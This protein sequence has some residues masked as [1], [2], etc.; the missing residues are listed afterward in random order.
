M[1]IQPRV[2]L[3]V[4]G[5]DAAEDLVGQAVAGEDDVVAADAVVG[6]VA[7]LAPEAV[8]RRAALHRIVV[9]PA[10]DAVLARF[11]VDAVVP[12]VAGDAVVAVAAVGAVLPA[13]GGDGVGAFAALD[14]VF[15]RTGVDVRA[16][17]HAGADH[18]VVVPVV[19][20]DVDACDAAGVERHRRGVPRD[21]VRR[22]VLGDGDAVVRGRTLHV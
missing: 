12:A 10:V 8:A 3:R 19:P 22:R 17:Q 15:A 11:A 14:D 7:A 20:V 13:A 4:V 18:D 6:V 16:E 21:R 5:A 1:H 9:L 2:D